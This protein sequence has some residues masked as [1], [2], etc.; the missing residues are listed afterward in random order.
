MS[1]S[2]NGKCD[3]YK[4]RPKNPYGSGYKSCICCNAWFKTN[5]VIFCK[6]CMT[7]LRSSTKTGRRVMPIRI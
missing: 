4:T 1:K 2:C 3:E 6:C 7:R 5:D